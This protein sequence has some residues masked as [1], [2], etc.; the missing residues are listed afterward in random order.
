MQDGE[1][2]LPQNEEQPHDYIEKLHIAL[3]IHIKTCKIA[4]SDWKVRYKLSKCR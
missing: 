3:H 4:E 2:V 1:K